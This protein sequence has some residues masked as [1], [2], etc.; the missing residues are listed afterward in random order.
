MNDDLPLGRRVAYPDN[1]DPSVLR[2]IQRRTAR[3]E[4]G[5]G[6]PLPFQGEDVW[7]CYEL[8][9]LTPAGLPRIGILT[10]RVP[11]DSPRI[12][13][14]KSLKLYL[15]GFGGSTFEHSAAVCSTIEGDL[16]RETGSP[17]RVSIG[18]PGDAQRLGEFATDCLDDLPV[19]VDRYERS[20]DL[21]TTNGETGSDAS[22]PICSVACARSPASRTGVRSPSPTVAACSS[23]P[24]C[25][26]T[27]CPTGTRRIST[28]WQPNESSP[29]STTRLT[30]RT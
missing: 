15:G 1:Y 28:K 7:N 23:A 3:Q 17:V 22:T 25:S 26:A 20:P 29:I 10:L 13:E 14:S 11:A 24:P 5:I 8:S 27:S 19:S 2:T 16:S 18:D 12:G 21:L 30:R 6:D 9:W 4:I